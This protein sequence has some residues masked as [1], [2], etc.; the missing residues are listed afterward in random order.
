[1]GDAAGTRPSLLIRVR[2]PQD[3]EAWGQFVALYGPLIYQFA[4]RQGLQDAD[5][6]DLTQI[7]LQAVID[8]MQRLDY[9]PERGSFRSWL[10]QVVRHQLSKFRAQQRL[11]PRGS[12]DS[13]AQRFLDELPDSDPGTIELWDREYERQ[14][15]LWA[16]ERV[17]ARCDAASWQAFWRTA[18]EGHGAQ[19]V[20]RSLGLSVGAVYTA[21]SRILD[22]IRKEIRQAQGDEGEFSRRGRDGDGELS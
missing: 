5:A 2:D 12:G 1:M 15:F 13:G 11:S 10:Y 14:L 17:K 18:V 7:V 21:R 19:E 20:A 22:R 9:D 8:A 6:A 4:R 16:G 3:A